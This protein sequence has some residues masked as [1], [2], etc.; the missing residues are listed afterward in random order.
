MSARTAVLMSFSGFVLPWIVWILEM[1]PLLL[2][3][4]LHTGT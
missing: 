3:G 1:C 2:Q 4:G